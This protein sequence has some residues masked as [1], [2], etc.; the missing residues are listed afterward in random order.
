MYKAG[1]SKKYVRASVLFY[2]IKNNV[3]EVLSMANLNFSLENKLKKK[4]C[5]VTSIERDKT[6]YNKQ[7]KINKNEIILK[8]KP[9]IK[10]DCSKY[11]GLFL[12]MCGPYSKDTHKAL[13]EVP[14]KGAVV[15][16]LLKSRE[17]KFAQQFIDL[18]D[19]VNSYLRLF[20]GLDYNVERY[21]EYKD[22]DNS[23][24]IVFFMKKL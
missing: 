11:N 16:T 23:P 6:I 18:N 4:G 15:I 21:I 14:S 20:A 22:W 24:M 2:F 5:N 13:Q 17:S 19:R 3:N 8:N 1:K 9:L 10:E 12:D 7:L